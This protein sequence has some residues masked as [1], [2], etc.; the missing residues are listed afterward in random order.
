MSD[1]ASRICFEAGIDVFNEHLKPVLNDWLEK[2]W[3]VR[4]SLSCEVYLDKVTP[5]DLASKEAERASGKARP[6][7]HSR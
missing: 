4:P 5:G 6:D 2:G 7:E 3:I 1:S